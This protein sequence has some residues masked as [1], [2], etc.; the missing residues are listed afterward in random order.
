MSD[1]DVTPALL[2]VLQEIQ[3]GIE[4]VGEG[5]VEVSASIR[6]DIRSERRERLIMQVPTFVFVVVAVILALLSL[7][8][9]HATQNS[10]DLII[11]CTTAGGECNRR[12]LQATSGAVARITADQ[13]THEDQVVRRVNCI[14]HTG[15][16]CP[17][18][19]PPSTTTTVTTSPPTTAP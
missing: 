17:A 13:Q 3:A 16:D 19:P 10:A 5:L 11:D 14:L 18:A 7:T 8:N 6:A 15:N 4:T 1:S 2:Q 9:I 12:N